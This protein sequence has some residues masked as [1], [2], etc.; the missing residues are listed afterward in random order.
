MDLSL[1]PK[2]KKK[3]ALGFAHTSDIKLLGA[4]GI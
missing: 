3:S 2:V 1:P 4:I